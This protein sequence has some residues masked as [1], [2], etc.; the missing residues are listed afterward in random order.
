VAVAANP[1]PA[2]INFAAVEAD[3]PLGRTPAVA[4][5]FSAAMTRTGQ[6]MRILAQHLLNRPDAGRQTEPLKRAVHISPSRFK[7]GHQRHR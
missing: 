6:P 1:R 7:A 3:L 4:N 5:A 2:H